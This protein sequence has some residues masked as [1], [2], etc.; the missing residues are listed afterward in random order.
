MPEI[1]EKGNK[2]RKGRERHGPLLRDRAIVI[3]YRKLG[4]ADRIVVLLTE[5]EGKRSGVAKGVRKTGS[6]F[7]GRLEPTTLVDILLYRGRSLDIIRQVEIL[8]SFRELREDLPRFTYASAML[9]LAERVT[10]EGEPSEAFALLLAALRELKK[11][12]GSLPFL[13]SMF[14]MKILIVSG[15]GPVLDRCVSCGG[16]AS[17]SRPVFSLKM[18]GVLCENCGAESRAEVGKRMR[19]HRE[20]LEAL[21]W[22]ADNEL[23]EWRDYKGGEGYLGEIRNL[24]ERFLEYWFEKEFKSR[25]MI[26]SLAKGEG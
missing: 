26:R 2:T 4:E 11:G 6:S 10:R 3:R 20:A 17:G 14:D 7:G 1:R 21:S 23:R 24:S 18:G 8:E 15:F 19:V 25:K 9:E 16:V 22:M 13:L 12:K 5:K